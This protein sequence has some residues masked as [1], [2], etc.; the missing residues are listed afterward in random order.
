MLPQAL[1]EPSQKPNRHFKSM[2]DETEQQILR[3]LR[4]MCQ[5]GE[6]AYTFAQALSEFQI[7]F[8][9]VRIA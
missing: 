5:D 3:V 7:S 8:P 6:E 1:G 2:S 9:E 4:G